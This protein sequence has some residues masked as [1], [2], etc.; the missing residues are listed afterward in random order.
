MEERVISGLVS[1]ASLLRDG[2]ATI[3]EII[4]EVEDPSEWPV[5]TI[6]KYGRYVEVEK[7]DVLSA[8]RGSEDR[9]VHVL[10]DLDL[11][12]DADLD[13]LIGWHGATAHV[14]VTCSCTHARAART[15]ASQVY[16]LSR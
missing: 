2:R 7:I 1:I 6:D 13:R 5:S 3:P 16:S 8:I 12:G 15:P 11:L 4:T 10:D 14:H 9:R